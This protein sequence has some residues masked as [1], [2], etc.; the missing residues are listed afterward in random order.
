[1]LFS[2]ELLDINHLH[3]VAF[4]AL[5]S[6]P[7]P[8]EAAVDT[9]LSCSCCCCLLTLVSEQIHPQQCA[10]EKFSILVMRRPR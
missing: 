8:P 5:I 10:D 4:K 7:P 9:E 3:L 1:M 2:N 6:S